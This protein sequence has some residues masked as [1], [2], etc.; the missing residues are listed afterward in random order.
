MTGSKA[1][2]TAVNRGFKSLSK[3]RYRSNVDNWDS[4]ATTASTTDQNKS[5]V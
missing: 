2:R 4:A 3:G 5:P 1:C